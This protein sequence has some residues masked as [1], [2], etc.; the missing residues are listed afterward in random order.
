MNL[1]CSGV[2][3][4][5]QAIRVI[6]LVESM[7]S[8]FSYKVMLVLFS[9]RPSFLLN[10]VVGGLTVTDDGR[11]GHLLLGET[12]WSEDVECMGRWTIWV[13]KK[14]DHR[15]GEMNGIDGSMEAIGRG[16]SRVC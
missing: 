10:I 7:T 4:S 1:I 9:F 11:A 8:K 6:I 16:G 15:S 14:N 5:F 2:M 12:E 13:S 3:L